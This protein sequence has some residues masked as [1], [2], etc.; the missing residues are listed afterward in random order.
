MAT[1]RRN[2]AR[3]V[4]AAAAV[5]AASTAVA[6]TAAAVARNG[7]CD[8]GEICFYYLDNLG[9]SVSDFTSSLANYGDTQPTCYEFRTSGLAGYGQCMK[10]NA[11]SAWNRN[12]SNVT[13]YFNSNYGKPCDRV[14]AGTWRNLDY[15][16]DENASHRFITTTCPY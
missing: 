13:V 16:Y 15:T 12:S 11:R 2:L 4:I 9:G 6:P 10:N 7:V 8:A 5:T 14:S 1:F 3:A